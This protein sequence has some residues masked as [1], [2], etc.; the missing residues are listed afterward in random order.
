MAH[1]A[2]IVGMIGTRLDHI[3][4]ACTQSPTHRCV[5]RERFTQP[6]EPLARQPGT[7]CAHP[8]PVFDNDRLRGAHL[9]K[10]PIEPLARNRRACLE[11]H[12][13][14]FAAVLAY[15]ATEQPHDARQDLRP[16]AQ[17][18]ACKQ[19]D[20]CRRRRH[21]IRGALAHSDAQG[22]HGRGL[23]QRATQRERHADEIYVFRTHRLARAA[24]GARQCR[25]GEFSGRGAGLQA[26]GTSLR[27]QARVARFAP[28][29]TDKKTQAAAAA[30]GVIVTACGGD[31]N[32]RRQKITS[33]LRIIAGSAL[34]FIAR[35]RS[36]SASPN[37]R[38]M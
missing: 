36:T 21:G 7:Q 31:C 38:R 8:D 10:E 24:Q 35:C 9:L 20:L 16:G 18:G 32:H 30:G 11:C 12:R 6:R 17:R 14:V 3:Q 15:A 23:G 29:R 2:L 1:Q 26:F 37:T 33:R 5:I 28:H 4:V 13:D 27:T 25:R 19:H 22:L 34:R